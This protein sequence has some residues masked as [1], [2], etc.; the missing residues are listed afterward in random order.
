MARFEPPTQ[1][2]FLA[3]ATS[4]KKDSSPALHAVAA[5]YDRATHSVDIRLSN[6]VSAVIPVELLPGLSQ[7]KPDDLREMT[8]EGR[9]YGLRVPALDADLSIP[10]LFESALGATGMARSHRRAVASR[11]NGRLGGRPRKEQAPE[12]A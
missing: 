5:R 2:Q 3:S 1:D 10:A 12:N 7:A 6:G 4:A 9:G 8:I 11:N